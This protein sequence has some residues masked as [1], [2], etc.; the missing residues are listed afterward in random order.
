[1]A[2]KKVAPK[3]SGASAKA[4]KAQSARMTA[5]AKAPAKAAAAKTDAARRKPISQPNGEMNLGQTW[6][7]NRTYSNSNVPKAIGK[8]L[9]DNSAQTY[10]TRSGKRMVTGTYKG[11]GSK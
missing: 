8:M 10:K 5:Q 9:V 6:K 3:D 7:K 2:M 4:K 11:K 1:M